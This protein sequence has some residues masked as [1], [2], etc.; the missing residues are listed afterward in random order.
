MSEPQA[1]CH[2]EMPNA[3]LHTG[4]GGYAVGRR[5]VHA[6]E[7][8]KRG[9]Q[10]D[11]W[12]GAVD[13]PLVLRENGKLPACA[14]VFQAQTTVRKNNLCRTAPRTVYRLGLDRQTLGQ[15]E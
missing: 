8:A 1:R 7:Q 3:R 12:P 9:A 14:V 5:A 10:F 6:L 15:L 13:S 2:L 4:T 11:E